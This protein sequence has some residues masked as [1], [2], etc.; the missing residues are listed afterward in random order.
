MFRLFWCLHVLGPFSF[1]KASSAS[2]AATMVWI[3]PE[4]MAPTVPDDEKYE[5]T[6]VDANVL[7]GWFTS[8]TPCAPTGWPGAS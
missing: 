8:H 1:C 3:D 7:Q 5:G 2:Q 4:F 6:E